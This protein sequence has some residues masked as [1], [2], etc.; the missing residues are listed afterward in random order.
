MPSRCQLFNVKNSLFPSGVF[1][2]LLIDFLQLGEM[3]RREEQQFQ[4]YC[5]LVWNQ[6]WKNS[7]WLWTEMVE[8]YS[9]WEAD[10]PLRV[11]FKIINLWRWMQNIWFLFNLQFLTSYSLL[12][13]RNDWHCILPNN[14]DIHI[15]TGMECIPDV[16]IP[17]LA[18]LLGTQC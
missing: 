2:F 10:R 8:L 12:L 11:S 13:A 15:S 4:E 5:S 16:Y 7:F 6:T 3:F 1:P 17:S 14:T 18:T 9:W